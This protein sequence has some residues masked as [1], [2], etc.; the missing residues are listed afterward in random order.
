MASQVKGRGFKHR[1]APLNLSKFMSEIIF[2][3]YHEL[4]GTCK[5]PNAQWARVVI[6][7]QIQIQIFKFKF[8]YLLKLWYIKMLYSKVNVPKL[9]ESGMQK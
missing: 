6:M 8:L 5:V 3:I 4:N 2:Q 1:L 7:P 9:P